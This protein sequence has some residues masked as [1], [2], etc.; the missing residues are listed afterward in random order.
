MVQFAAHPRIK[1]GLAQ[2][3]KGFEQIR[4]HEILK[5]IEPF[6]LAIQIGDYH[7]AS[8]ARNAHEFS[9]CPLW[10]RKILETEPRPRVV[11]TR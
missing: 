10:F 7:D 11:E 9:Q 5:R 3:P 2:Q 8:R 4:L 1:V 6:Q